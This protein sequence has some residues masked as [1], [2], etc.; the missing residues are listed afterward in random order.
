MK[1]E[2]LA[3]KKSTNAM[4]TCKCGEVFE[5]EFFYNM[6]T[7]SYIT[8]KNCPGCGKDN[9]VKKTVYEDT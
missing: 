5:S 6:K 2:W 9:S 4:C 3:P 1:V 7:K 8:M